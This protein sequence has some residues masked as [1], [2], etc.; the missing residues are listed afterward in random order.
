MFSKDNIPLSSFCNIGTR[1]KGKEEK[2]KSAFPL[3]ATILFSA[4]Y[5]LNGLTSA[6]INDSDFQRDLC[7]LSLKYISA[8]E[9]QPEISAGMRLLSTMV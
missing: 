4:G 8:T 2:R 9:T 5:N 3:L 6:L 1:V 7:R